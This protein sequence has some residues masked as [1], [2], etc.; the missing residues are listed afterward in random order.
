MS[1]TGLAA[2]FSVEYKNG[3]VSNFNG[4][5]HATGL[6]VAGASRRARALNQARVASKGRENFGAVLFRKR[7]VRSAIFAFFAVHNPDLVALGTS[8]PR[9]PFFHA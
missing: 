4:S 5:T 1:I 7:K 6:P 9:R 3:L 8:L 2:Q